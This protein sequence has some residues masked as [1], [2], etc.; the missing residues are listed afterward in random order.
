MVNPRDRAEIGFRYWGMYSTKGAAVTAAKKL[1]SPA[2]VVECTPVWVSK[3]I[4]GPTS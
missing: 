3:G 1:G 4:N 2:R